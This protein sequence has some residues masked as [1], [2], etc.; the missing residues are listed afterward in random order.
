MGDIK[1]TA[2]KWPSL[3]FEIKIADLN[4]LLSQFLQ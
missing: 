3:N 1:K 4:A 2:D